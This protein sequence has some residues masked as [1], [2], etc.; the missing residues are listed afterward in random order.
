MQFEKWYYTY[1]YSSRKYDTNFLNRYKKL[2][3]TRSPK[4]SAFLNAKILLAVNANKGNLTA[5]MV[6]QRYYVIPFSIIRQSHKKLLNKIKD[7][8]SFEIALNAARTG[9][10]SYN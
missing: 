1:R 3:S 9:S 2:I 7:V 4:S 8:F 6:A 5:T 10:P